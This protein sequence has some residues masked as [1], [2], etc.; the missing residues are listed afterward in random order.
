MYRS[1]VRFY[2]ASNDPTEIL[3]TDTCRPY[4]FSFK[5]LLYMSIKTFYVN[6]YDKKLGTKSP[7]E[8]QLFTHFDV[9][10]S[11]DLI[12]LCDM[13]VFGYTWEIRVI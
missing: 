1:A 7:I 11:D 12:I 3:P 8:L 2:D 9:F 10:M 4:L 13:L 6:K 5:L